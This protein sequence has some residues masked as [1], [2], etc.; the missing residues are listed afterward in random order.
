MWAL[1]FSVIDIAD[2]TKFEVSRHLNQRDGFTVYN[3]LIIGKNI[4]TAQTKPFGLNI[5]QTRYR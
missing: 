2:F 1:C 4:L 3:K 5:L